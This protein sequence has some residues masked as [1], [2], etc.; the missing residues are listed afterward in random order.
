MHFFVFSLKRLSKLFV[1][2]CRN[3]IERR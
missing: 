2:S 3:R 1:V